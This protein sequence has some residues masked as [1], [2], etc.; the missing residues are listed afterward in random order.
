MTTREAYNRWYW[1]SR[2]GRKTQQRYRHSAKG[3]A[4]RERATAKQAVKRAANRPGRKQ[5]RP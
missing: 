2:K 3:Q 1:K 4:T 5:V